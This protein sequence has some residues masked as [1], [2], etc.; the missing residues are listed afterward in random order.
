M[1]NFGIILSN[2][3]RVFG[4]LWIILEA[5]T[6]FVG[7]E[8]SNDLRSFWWVFLLIGLGVSGYNLYPKRR[9]K[10]KITDRDITVELVIGDIFKQD[11]PII[12]G[13]NDGLV[14]SKD[15]IS[16]NS[17][18]GKFAE[19]YLSSSLDLRENLKGS[20][21][22]GKVPIGTTITVQGNGKMGYFC[23]IA[24]IN[25]S[26]I[27]K[28]NLEN[29]RVSLAELWNYLGTHGEKAIFNIPVLGSGFSRVPIS[30]QD[31]SKEIIGSFVAS[32]RE[33]TF[34]DGLRLV[35]HPSDIRKFNIDIPDIVKFIEY[36]CLH[37]FVSAS[38]NG[39]RGK[40]ES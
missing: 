37:S 15:V 17:I 3:L 36:S 8:L 33:N 9:Y 18:Q 29:I 10:F 5:T 23:A 24:E 1:H 38:S 19:K 22:D 40:P 28:S 20:N 30:R 13:C 12:V 16:D 4:A 27:C 14:T 11:G 6:F 39:P 21:S 26:G 2:L 34:C 7:A 35:I 31:L 25:S 32:T